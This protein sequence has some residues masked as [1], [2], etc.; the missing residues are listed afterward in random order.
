M[1]DI[2]T[3]CEGKCRKQCH[4]RVRAQELDEVTRRYRKRGLPKPSKG[5][6]E[7]RWKLSP[8]RGILSA[9]SDSEGYLTCYQF[10]KSAL[11]HC[12]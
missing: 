6:A 4:L 7:R 10:Q 11:T 9:A 12:T 8:V 2:F 3:F 1:E 5:D